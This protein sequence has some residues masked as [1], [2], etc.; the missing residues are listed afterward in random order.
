MSY[1]VP[2]RAVPRTNGWAIAALVT[3]LC[4]LVIPPVIC[5][6]IALIQIRGSGQGGQVLAVIG[7]VLGY[8][9]IVAVVIVLLAA[10]GLTI[11]GLNQ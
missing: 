4:G 3:A 2:S 5:G 6:H 11:W 10:A 1:A 8:L 9:Q 7:I